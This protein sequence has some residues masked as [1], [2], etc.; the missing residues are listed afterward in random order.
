[1]SLS[2]GIVVVW[3]NESWAFYK[4]WADATKNVRGL[5]W[6]KSS[7]DW[8]DDPWNQRVDYNE[9]L[10]TASVDV[11]KDRSKKAFPGSRTQV[12]K[13]SVK[14]TGLRF[15]RRH[16]GWPAPVQNNVPSPNSNVAA[17]YKGLGKIDHF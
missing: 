3:M 1:M 17:G 6:S 12:K 7:A 2:Y 15:K 8:T 9:N 16:G 11:T 5:D 14:E 10:T 13:A 4:S